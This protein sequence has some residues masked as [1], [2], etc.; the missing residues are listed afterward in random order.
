[1]DALEHRV[2]GI[3]NANTTLFNQVQNLQAQNQELKKQLDERPADAHHLKT[4]VKSAQPDEY[5]GNRDKLNHFINSL[6][7]YVALERKELTDEELIIVALSFIKKGRAVTWAENYLET[8]NL[9]TQKYEDFVAALRDSFGDSDIALMAQMTLD[10]L[11]QGSSSM[12][13]YITTFEQHEGHSQL[14]EVALISAF[15]KGLNGPLLDKIHQVPDLPATLKS[16][17]SFAQRIDTNWRIRRQMQ[18]NSNIFARTARPA[19]SSTTP[20]PRPVYAPRKDPNAMD[21]D[22][23][24]TNVPCP[25]RPLAE[26]TCFRCRKKGH[27]SCDCMEPYSRAKDIRYMTD[28]QLA[29]HLKEKGF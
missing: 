25:T 10:T 4:A 27:Y 3:L 28:E 5:D 24:R 22:A 12:T 16:W 21:I 6:S 7:L 13:E 11:R 20:V 8:G 17:K 9:K 2:Q 29:E 15:K 26:I 19:S 1:M 23:S 14:G 18:G